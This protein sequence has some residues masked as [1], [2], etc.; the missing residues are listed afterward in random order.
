MSI[1]TSTTGHSAKGERHIARILY[2]AIVVAVLAGLAFF[3]LVGQKDNLSPM[4]T[5]DPSKS[6]PAASQPSA[7]T[8]P[9]Q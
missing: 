3:F 7:P 2:A 4:K 5:D 9:A 6:A 8:A 1:V